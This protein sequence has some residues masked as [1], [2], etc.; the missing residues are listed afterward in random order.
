MMYM[1][2]VQPQ[3]RYTGQVRGERTGGSLSA[4]CLEEESQGHK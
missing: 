4:C 3:G 2:Q 1:D